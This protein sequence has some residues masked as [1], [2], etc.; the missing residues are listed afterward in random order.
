MWSHF[1]QLLM[2]R[3]FL[4]FYVVKCPNDISVTFVDRLIRRQTWIFGS[5]DFN[6]CEIPIT[7]IKSSNPIWFSHVTLL[8]DSHGHHKDACDQ[9]QN[10]KDMIQHV[11]H[12]W[13]FAHA[14]AHTYMYMCMY[15]RRQ[16]TESWLQSQLFDLNS[17]NMPNKSWKRLQTRRNFFPIYRFRHLHILYWVA[18][19]SIYGCRL[20]PLNECNEFGSFTTDWNFMV[21]GIG[22]KRCLCHDV[23]TKKFKFIWEN[24]IDQKTV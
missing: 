22:V 11:G 24:E 17:C 3:Q 15:I 16:V 7:L 14:Q 21:W 4:W 19:V 20:Q 12:F 9:R 2:I 1:K 10:R 13:C 8:V 5:I 23:W 18:R 6:I